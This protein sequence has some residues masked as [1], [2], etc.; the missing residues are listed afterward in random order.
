[1]KFL[2]WNI[3]GGADYE[4]EI[5]YIQK[6][7][8]D[9]FCLQE[10]Q[11]NY[12]GHYEG[13]DIDVLAAFRNAFLGHRGVFAPINYMIDNGLERAFG[14]A[15]F[16]RFPIVAEKPVYFRKQADWT[17]HDHQNQSRNLVVTRLG[18]DGALL[19]VATCHLTYEPYF[20]DTPQQEE[21]AE[22]ILIALQSEPAV[23]LA[24]DFNSLPGSKVVRKILDTFVSVP[25]QE[26]LTFARI[27]WGYNDFHVNSLQYKLDYILHSRSLV[28]SNLA[29]PDT[30]LSDHLPLAAIINFRGQ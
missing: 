5:E 12:P 11:V 2:T 1:M 25:G 15:I 29:L 10:V 17:P 3:L 14:N 20:K 6:I 7:D 21:E 28:S 24:G 23:I 18:I 8:P 26:F 30:D 9:V 13:R 16:S 22:R 4:R 19:T 27:P